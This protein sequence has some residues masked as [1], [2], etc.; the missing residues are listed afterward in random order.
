MFEKAKWIENHVCPDA[1][2]P[3]F[4]KEFILEEYK[5][6]SISICGVG[7][8]T[9]EINGERVSDELLTPPFTAY[10]KRVLYQTYDVTKHLRQGKN[11]IQV[12]CGNGWYNQ[13]ENDGWD[14]GHA[15]WRAKPQM[16]CQMNVDDKCFLVS[17]SSWETTEGLTVQNSHRGGETYYTFRKIENFHPAHIAHGPGGVLEPQKMPP[18]KL[19][20]TYEGKEIYPYLYDF[21]QS[22]TGNIEVKLQGNCGD[23]FVME[24]SERIRDDG[25]LDRENVAMHV[26]NK[27]F[28][29]DEYILSGEGVETWHGEFAFHGFRY[30]R[31]YHP[32]TT[33]VISV[34]ARDMHTDL[35]RAGDYK[36]SNEVINQLHQACLRSLLTNYI[37]IP[38]DCPHREKNGW[39]A[40]GMLSSFQALYNF[41]MKESYMKWLDDIVDCQRPNG[42]IPCIAPTSIWGY[43]WG[44]GSTWDAVLLILPWNIYNYT[45]D[46]SVI[47]RYYPAIKKY[48]TFLE[49]QSDNDI[50][51]NGLGDWCAPEKVAVCD[52]RAVVTGYAKHLFDLYEKM[53]EVLGETENQEYAARRSKEIKDAYIKEFSKPEELSQTYCAL[54]VYLDLTDDKQAMAD[55]LAELVEKAGKHIEAGIFGAFMVPIVLREYGYFDLA[56]EMICNEEYPGWIY[57]MKKCH[58]T[59]GETW[60]GHSSLDHHMFTP[61]DGFVNESLSGFRM[62]LGSAGFDKIELKP[63]FPKDLDNFEAWYET[64]NGKIE[65]KWDRDTYSVVV[66]E[67]ISG[68]VEL[69]GKFYELKTGRNDIKKS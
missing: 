48:M 47:E 20:G 42:A 67:G 28:A 13:Q 2:T 24:Y 1:I 15:T 38:M 53:S 7:F 22:I 16:I 69:S 43:G 29:R 11:T 31:V 19:H 25:T 46:I 60:I 56:W 63:Y 10:D 26:S 58:G 27:R 8:Y 54:S 55:K 33:K 45:G 34:T 57:L 18:V 61:V 68:V 6:A 59:I 39:T 17:D 4:R 50:F 36:C 65:I 52:E 40:D 3:V 66:P 12:V 64:A 49:T 41:D 23:D 5:N 51:C 9:L 14:F 62:D 37:H 35:Q 21:G 30:V 44:S 32:K